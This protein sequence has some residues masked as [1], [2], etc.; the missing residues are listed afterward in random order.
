MPIRDRAPAAPGNSSVARCTAS[1]FALQRAL[2][3]FR[4]D[5]VHTHSAKAGFLGRLAAWSLQRAGDRAHRSRCAVSSVSECRGAHAL[6]L[7]RAVRRPPLPCADQRGRRDDRSAG[8]GRRRP[9][10]KVHDDLQRHGCRAV[11]AGR[12]ASRADARELG[13]AD[14]H[15]VVGK[16][17][18]LFHLKGHDYVIRAAAEVVASQSQR[19][20]PV[21]RRRPL[22]RAAAA[23][24]R[25]GGPDRSI[26]ASPASCRPQIPD[27]LG[28]MDILVHASLREGLARALPQALIAGKPVVSY[29]VDGAPKWRSTARPAFSSRRDWPALVE[30][31]T[32]T[33]QRPRPARAARPDRPRAVRRP[34]RHET[35]TRRIREL[36]ERLLAGEASRSSKPGT[37]RDRKPLRPTLPT[38]TT[39]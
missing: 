8:A 27:Y 16:I 11:S 18:R 39:R 6:P 1:Y 33:C 14:E 28:A 21:R 12:R 10:R 22:A 32:S 25:R 7:V 5:V 13:F 15:V 4:P 34:F 17:A 31:L 35:M 3:E 26:S 2:R 38:A 36:Y 37:E 24:D 19:P 29:D 20:L 30:P 9:A 23:A